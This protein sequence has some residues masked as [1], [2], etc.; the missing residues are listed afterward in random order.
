MLRKAR[1]FGQSSVLDA[2]AQNGRNSSESELRRSKL[3]RTNRLWRRDHKKR[4]MQRRETWADTRDGQA[5]IKS[6]TTGVSRSTQVS[7]QV[8]CG[9]FNWRIRFDGNSIEWPLKNSIWWN[10]NFI[11]VI[12]ECDVIS[13]KMFL[14]WFGLMLRESLNSFHSGLI[15]FELI[16]STKESLIFNREFDWVQS[17]WNYSNL[18]PKNQLIHVDSNEIYFHSSL[19][20]H[21]MELCYNHVLCTMW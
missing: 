2:T 1:R 11:L 6:C 10:W 18:F 15:Q 4:A 8:I 20:Q 9:F 12:F 5:G 21:D 7:Y 16:E 14:I 17:S 3:L 13:W 19:L